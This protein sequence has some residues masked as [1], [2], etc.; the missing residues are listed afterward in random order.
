LAELPG[1]IL[2]PGTP[3][4]NMIFAGLSEQVP[5]DTR[6]V[7]QRLAEQGVRVGVVG[8]RRFRM[9]LHYWINDAGLEKTLQAFKSVL[10]G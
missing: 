6:E 8:K 4:T 7:V 2:D 9:V 5:L 10:L 3:Y 1:I